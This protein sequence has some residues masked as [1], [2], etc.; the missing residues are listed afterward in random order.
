MR[1]V[2]NKDW[3]TRRLEADVLIIGGGTAGCYAAWTLRG[4]GLRVI[5]AE[6]ADIRR[7]G[8]LAAGVNAINAYINP[9]YTAEDYVDYVRRDAEGLI[10]ED[11]VRTVAEGVNSAARDLEQLGLVFQKD[12]KGNYASRGARN[13]KI[14]GENI[15]PVLA[16]AAAQDNV[17]VLNHVNITD[18]L[19]DRGRVCGARGFDV[20]EP[21]AYEL[22][23]G[24]VICATGGAAGLFLPNHPGFSRH[25][26]WYCPFN[27]GSGYAMGIRAGAEMTTFE[28]RFV[29]L[30]CRDTIAPTGTIAQ[31]VGARQVNREGACYESDYPRNTSGRVYGTTEENRQGRGPCR[32][33]TA[34]IT[35]EQE[36]NLY[37][38]YLNMAPSQTLRWIESGNGPSAEGVE[39]EGT[40]PYVVGGHSACGY[41]VDVRRETTLP[42]LFAAGDVAGGCPQKYVSGAMV[43]G[44]I[45]AESAA[46]WCR[47]R[48]APEYGSAGNAA[49]EYQAF[50]CSSG[51]LFTC[52]QVE[53]AMQQAMDRWA[54]GRTVDYRY[55]FGSL[56][57]AAGRIRELQELWEGLQA[58]DMD[59]LLRIY[60]LRDRLAVCQVLIAHM[61]A[62]K[63]TRWPGFGVNTDC[64]R[65]SEQELSFVNSRMSGGEIRILRRPLEAGGI[66]EHTD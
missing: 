33:D 29:A 5:L 50:F 11:L 1:K 57:K 16:A 38:A 65:I 9:G 37:K 63:E 2:R 60:E 44:R 8:C 30:R 36:E 3:E 48:P 41:W 6:K 32:L 4:S 27:A 34:G 62:R 14:N 17:T 47:S 51:S 56:E 66:Y 53:E 58:D 40:E 49:A 46:E 22:L 7:S 10:R 35:R 18:Y 24:A 21:V 20:R 45:A 55:S 28:M 31:G 12:E 19:L 52:R 13:V 39:V 26:M 15:K 61:A 42:G 43:E 59:E 23:A 25:K 54:G 64:P